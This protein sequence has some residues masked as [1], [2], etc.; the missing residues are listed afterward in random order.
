[1]AG[2]VDRLQALVRRIDAAS[3][4]EVEV[5]PLRHAGAAEVARTLGALEQGGAGGTAAAQPGGSRMIADDRTNSILL[6]GDPSQR[7]RLRT[8]I[9]HL[10]TPL[11]GNENTQ[12]LFLRNAKATDLVPILEGVAATLTGDTP[13][14]ESTKT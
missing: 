1:R 12:V 10:D 3:D 13:G 11:E 4:A 7:L 8:L 9:A 5:I 6:S 2:N 14:A